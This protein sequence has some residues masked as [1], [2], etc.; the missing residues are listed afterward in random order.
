MLLRLISQ[1]TKPNDPTKHFFDASAR[2]SVV[3]MGNAINQEVL[4]VG[5]TVSGKV[6]AYTKGKAL[7][8]IDGSKFTG[9]MNPN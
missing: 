8:K 1:K 3:K 5:L 9:I 2:E 7:V 6:S 4:M